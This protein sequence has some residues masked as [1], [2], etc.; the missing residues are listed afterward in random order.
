MKTEKKIETS[1]QFAN[2]LIKVTTAVNFEISTQ[3]L[4]SK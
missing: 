2:L 1:L 3:L 4:K